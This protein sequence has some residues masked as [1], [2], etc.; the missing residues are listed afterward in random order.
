MK[1]L[2]K[3]ECD[4]TGGDPPGSPIEVH[5]RPMGDRTQSAMTA[6]AAAPIGA[7]PRGAVLPVPLLIILCMTGGATATAG[8]DA[9]NGTRPFVDRIAG[10]CYDRRVMD[11]G[12]RVTGHQRIRVHES[13][14]GP[15]GPEAPIDVVRFRAGG[16]DGALQV[17]DRYEF[18]LVGEIDGDAREE[19]ALQ[20]IGYVGSNSRVSLDFLDGVMIYPVEPCHGERLPPVR[21]DLSVEGGL[22]AL[23]GGRAEIR[24]KDRECR[25][26]DIEGG[27]VIESTLDMRMY[28]LGVPFK[29]EHY[30]SRHLVDADRGLVWHILE[31]PDGGR[32]ELT[33]MDNAACDPPW[34]PLEYD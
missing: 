7:Q 13:A 4:G 27:Y 23:L 15:R 5:W 3:P 14:N 29:K 11:A 30:S 28:L 21:L 2:C 20:I 19:A 12:G 34:K 31:S 33:M 26:A 16:S 8:A 25:S 6:P 9:G 10:N 18:K 32:Q 24:I 22:V 17:D 1:R